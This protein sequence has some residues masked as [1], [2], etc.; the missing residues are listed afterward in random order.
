MVA[1][2]VARAVGAGERDGVC[3]AVQ[4][5]FAAA[6]LMLVPGI[7]AVWYAADVVLLLA[8]DRSVPDLGR[9]YAHAMALAMVPMLFVTVWRNLFGALGRPKIFLAAMSA[10]LP[11]NAVANLVLMFGWG[12]VPVLGITGAGIAS[13]LVAFA[14][15]GGFATFTAFDSELRG[16]RLFRAPARSILGDVRENFRLGLPVGAFT[17]GEVGMFL[18]ATV[19]V[20]LFGAEALAAHAVAL[21]VAGVVYAI[22]AGL[23]Q[24]ATVRAGAAIG[25]GESGSID[26]CRGLG[27]DGRR[28][29]GHR[30][31][32]RPCSG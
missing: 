7:A 4:S 31:L 6:V 28:C 26:P 3:R 19:V 24:A 32:H 21:R 27:H 2:L 14:L 20:S 23:T 30:H 9:G 11:L 13:A 18:I 10:A 15:L 1:A 16:L 22:P 8:V 17:L 29:V 12:P 5:G 25:R